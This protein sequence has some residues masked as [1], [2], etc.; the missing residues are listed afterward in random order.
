MSVLFIALCAQFNIEA[1]TLDLPTQQKLKA[2]QNY[3]ILAEKT[4]P[5][6]AY[7]YELLATELYMQIGDLHKAEA[8]LAALS[9][10]ALPIPLHQLKAKLE[11]ALLKLNEEKLPPVEEISDTAHIALLLPLKGPHAQPAQAIK[12]GF[13]AYH[14]ENALPIKL[15][16]TTQNSDIGALYYQAVG[17]GAQFV[18]GPLVKEEVYNLSKLTQST[19]PIP[20][21]ALNAHPDVKISA[22]KPFFQF[23]LSPE[24]E[25]KSLADKAWEQGHKST[26]I[27][28]PDNEWGKRVLNAFSTQWH[29]LGGTIPSTARI[30]AQQ[31][32][33]SSIRTLL[34]ISHSYDPKKNQKNKTKEPA[35]RQDID[36]I[37]LA[38]PPEQARQLRPLLEFYE[39]QDLPVYST[40]SVYSGVPNPQQDRDLN[41][42]IFCDMPFI[43]NNLQDSAPSGSLA[44]LYA[45]G[46]DAYQLMARLPILSQSANAQYHGATGLLSIGAN[47]KVERELSWAQIKNGVPLGL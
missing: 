13:L 46:L 30:K 33:A 44:R 16:D 9:H 17:N 35:R 22:S 36:M 45:M 29:S 20:V 47:H 14:K 11:N 6:Q 8:L 41:G 34:K 28:V 38:A 42:I 15:Y 37:V 7:H 24:E 21:L 27:I 25:A 1:A 26:S 4:P 39:A 3:L 5:P 32:P 43:L 12:A 40:S 31:D 18:I 19:L 10:T 2:A 23:A